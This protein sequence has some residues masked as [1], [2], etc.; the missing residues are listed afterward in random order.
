MAVVFRKKIKRNSND[1]LNIKW[2]N[3]IME[4]YLGDAGGNGVFIQSRFL[5]IRLG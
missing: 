4:F 2:F 5:N 3:V 1:L